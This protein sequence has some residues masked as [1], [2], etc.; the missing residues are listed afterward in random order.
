MPFPG[1]TALAATPNPCDQRVLRTVTFT[2]KSSA[3]R[4]R[5]TYKDTAAVVSNNGGA[6]LVVGRIDNVAIAN[7]TGLRMFFGLLPVGT[8]FYSLLCVVHAGWLRRWCAAGQPHV[9]VH[10]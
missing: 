4:L 8:N 3:T 7:P 5:V 9:V 2:K 10:L 6:A 1:A